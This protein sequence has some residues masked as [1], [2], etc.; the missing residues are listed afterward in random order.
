MLQSWAGLM[1]LALNSPCH[2]PSGDA[3]APVAGCHQPSPCTVPP[4]SCASMRVSVQRAPRCS[5]SAFSRSSGRR[6]W[7]AGPLAALASRTSARQASPSGR[8]CTVPLSNVAGACGQSAARSSRFMVASADSMGWGSHGRRRA[9]A[10]S[11]VASMPAAPPVVRRLA[12]A[13]SAASTVASVPVMRATA[14]SVTASPPPGT[15]VCTSPC[16]STRKGMGACA[17]ST[18]CTW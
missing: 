18:A 2:W 10:S 12:V 6:C 9:L 17:P 8:A 1:R 16:A 3:C 11:V 13:S 14:L 7:S 4:P 15:V 5:R